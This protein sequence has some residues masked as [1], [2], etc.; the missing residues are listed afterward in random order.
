V[1][2]IATSGGGGGKSSA[3]TVRAAPANAPLSQQLNTL[4]RMIDRVSGQ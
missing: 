2:V 3:A 4:D 1:I